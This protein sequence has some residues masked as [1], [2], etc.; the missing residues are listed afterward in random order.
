MIRRRGAGDSSQPPSSVTAPGKFSRTWSG[1]N[2]TAPPGRQ[3]T[4]GLH[5]APQVGLCRQ[6]WTR[7][8]MSPRVGVEGAAHE[9]PVSGRRPSIGPSHA[10]GNDVFQI[11]YKE[12]PDRCTGSVRFSDWLV[13]APSFAV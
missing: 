7:T 13:K 10:Y 1:A 12:A 5:G 9:R 2:S 4:H 8:A 6:T 11:N 3:W